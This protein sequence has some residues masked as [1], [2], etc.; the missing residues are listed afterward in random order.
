MS[1][2]WASRPH[3]PRCR[4][5]SATAIPGCRAGSSPGWPPPPCRLAGGRGPPRGPSP[6]P[7][8]PA[9]FPLGPLNFR[10]SG[11][12][13]AAG[14]LPPPSVI[15]RHYPEAAAAPRP[16]RALLDAVIGRTAALIAQWQLVGF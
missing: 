8:P 13:G 15:A 9:L 14:P 5:P 4:S 10:P 1:L 6:A 7:V 16:Y 11:G 3:P 12:G 2:P